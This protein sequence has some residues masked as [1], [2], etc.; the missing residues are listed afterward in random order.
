MLCTILRIQSSYASIC[1][2]S[3]KELCQVDLNG[4][5]GHLDIR[6]CLLVINSCLSCVLIKII[7]LYVC[8]C[9]Y[10][11][12]LLLRPAY[13]DQIFVLCVSLYGI[14]CIVYIQNAGALI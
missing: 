7:I 12:L 14:Q 13:T 2:D 1:S 9:I 5:A 3:L 8:I 4:A 10:I 6:L 11:G